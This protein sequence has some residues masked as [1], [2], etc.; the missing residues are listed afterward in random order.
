[1]RFRWRRLLLII[2]VFIFALGCGGSS[3]PST[4]T[5]EPP[6][7]FS[8]TP[9]Q[10]FDQVILTWSPPPN[11]VE[12][13][14]FEARQGEGTFQKVHQGL[15]PATTVAL[16]LD[17]DP[18]T[19]ECQVFGFRA[20]SISQGKASPYTSEW[21]YRRGIRPAAISASRAAAGVQ[22]SW[23]SAS[24]VNPE[25]WLERSSD[26]G[27][28]WTAISPSWIGESGAV[29]SAEDLNASESERYQYR[30]TLKKSGFEARSQ[31][32]N[33][34][35]PQVSA[36]GIVEV[37]VEGSQ[38]HFQWINRSR[39]AQK[40]VLYRND[41]AIIVA[42]LAPGATS[43]TD[44]VPQPGRYRYG[45]AAEAAGLQPGFA[46]WCSVEVMPGN[47]GPSLPGAN[48]SCPYGND[49]Q[50]A[51]NGTWSILAQEHLWTE[52]PSGWQ[53]HPLSRPP[54]GTPSPVQKLDAQGRPHLLYA[55]PS[56]SGKSAL[57]HEWFDGSAWQTETLAERNLEQV[58]PERPLALALSGDGMP[59]AAWFNN[60]GFGPSRI[61]WAYK[62]DGSWRTGSVGADA[63]TLGD[64][65]FLRAAVGA[66]ES[67]HLLFDL[68]KTLRWWRVLPDGHTETED[69]ISP[70]S[71]PESAPYLGKFDWQASDSQHTTIAI[72]TST[73]YDQNIM[74]FTGALWVY[75]KRQGQWEVPHRLGMRPHDA[76]PTASSPLLAQ[77]LDGAQLAVLYHSALGNQ[78]HLFRD[79]HWLSTLL[80]VDEVSNWGLGFDSLGRVGVLLNPDQGN[81]ITL[82]HRLYLE[83]PAPFA[84]GSS[85]WVLR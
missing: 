14:E 13:Y 31:V 68:G 17:F 23:T 41:L 35:Y 32:S 60:E 3:T 11:S 59:L 19:P 43:Y 78:V 66:D 50:R 8:G 56:A 46:P 21:Q 18:A 77:S 39:I 53:D 80:P 55:T 44:E 73:T 24:A 33:E 76:Y 52:A 75:Q 61:E 65:T 79:Q 48:W 47:P 63:N 62:T 4:P 83:A 16:T 27:V 70:G 37:R 85:P 51:P 64:P 49:Y 67:L 5:L 20:R 36:P 34:V 84:R 38:V 10:G 22:V 25:P 7:S 74:G 57:V 54:L 42:N 2:P 30:V 82:P 28:N 45:L 26:G 81:G 12:G 58:Y 9:G 1:M 71:S 72:D 40:I 6:A 29:A 15:L 69:I